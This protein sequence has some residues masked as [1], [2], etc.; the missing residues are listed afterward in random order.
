MSEALC[1]GG[2]GHAGPTAAPMAGAATAL[3]HGL[4]VVTRNVADFA[5][6]G[7]EIIDPW[8][9]ARRADLTGQGIGSWFAKTCP[10]A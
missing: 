3:V 2:L 8:Q 10:P 5:P 1:G 9:A 6:T 4:S 7:A